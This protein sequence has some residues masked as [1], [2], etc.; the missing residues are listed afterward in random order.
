MTP[1]AAGMVLG[2]A[3]G[4]DPKIENGSLEIIDNDASTQQHKIL[5]SLL[6]Y[7]VII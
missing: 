3:D 4:A 1:A 7:I 2:R 5:A 6:Q